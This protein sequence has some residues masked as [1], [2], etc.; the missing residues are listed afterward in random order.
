MKP[1][2]KATLVAV[3]LFFAPI[4]IAVALELN[5][6]IENC[7][8]SVGKPI[9]VGCMRGGGN[10]EACRERA[11]PKVK[12]CVRSAMVAA[13]PKQE[14]RLPPCSALILSYFSIQR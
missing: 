9:V 2:A 11:T 10:L 13:L 12:A 8:A 14:L 7:R 3:L 5:Q 6:A 4:S 1:I